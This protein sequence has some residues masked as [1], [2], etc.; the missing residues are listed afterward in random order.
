MRLTTGTKEITK[1]VVEAAREP[2]L[3]QGYRADWTAVHGG[4][5]RGNVVISDAPADYAD[6]CDSLA[7]PFGSRSRSITLRDKADREEQFRL[8]CIL[9]VPR[10]HLGCIAGGAGSHQ[11][12]NPRSSAAKDRLAS[13][14]FWCPVTGC[15]RKNVSQLLRAQ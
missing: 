8:R 9:R 12:R 14:R 5:E 11:R 2:G 3:G 4:I 15:I 13:V 7:G 1:A 10:D 6:Y